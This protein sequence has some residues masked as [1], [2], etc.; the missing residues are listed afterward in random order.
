MAVDPITKEKGCS[1][2]RPFYKNKTD[3]PELK[4]LTPAERTEVWAATAGAQFRD[5]LIIL[6]VLCC[7]LLAGSGYFV[8]QQIV[9]GYWGIIIGAI[10]GNTVAW[11]L[12]WYFT[13]ERV[14][15]HLA[16]TIEKRRLKK[17]QA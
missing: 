17:E 10:I 12:F 7:G 1:V 6:A 3:I 15:P 4:P 8:G 2:M 14:R 16:A 11:T 9:C 13:A 5:P